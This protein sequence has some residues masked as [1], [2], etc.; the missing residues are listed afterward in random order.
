[1]DYKKLISAVLGKFVAMCI[2]AFISKMTYNVI[3]YEFNLPPF[4]FW[5]HLGVIYVLRYIL[6]DKKINEE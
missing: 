4:S 2:V 1:M 5:I 6:H 3:A